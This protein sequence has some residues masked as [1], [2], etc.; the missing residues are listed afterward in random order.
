MFR[1][2]F[3]SDKHDTISRDTLMI[4]PAINSDVARIR[5]QRRTHR[6]QAAT[7]ANVENEE[8]MPAA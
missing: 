4:P 6:E 7:A 1:S 5:K 2:E 3:A 8:P